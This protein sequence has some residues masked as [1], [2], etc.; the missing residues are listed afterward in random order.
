MNTAMIRITDIGL[1]I[2]AALAVMGYAGKVSMGHAFTILALMVAV[3]SIVKRLEPLSKLDQEQLK[4]AAKNIG[5]I[6]IPLGLAVGLM[7][8]EIGIL[9]DK[10]KVKWGQVNL[11]TAGVMISMM[12]MIMTLADVVTRIAKIPQEDF[13][14]ASRVIQSLLLTLTAAVALMGGNVGGKD[15]F[16]WGDVDFKTFAVMT[17]LI[18]GIIMLVNQVT[19]LAEVSKDNSSGL[20]QGT[21]IIGALAATLVGVIGLYGMIENKFG[22]F[23][24][25]DIFMVATV[26][27]G[28][29][30]LGSLANKLGEMPLGEALQG[31]GSII[32]IVAA[33][34][35]ATY[36]LGSIKSVVW[37]V[38]V[39]MVLMGG[40]VWLIGNILQQ[41]AGIEGIP[42][43][44]LVIGGIVL[45]MGIA[46]AL[47]NMVGQGGSGLT[48]VGT[49]LAMAVVVAAAGW[50]LSQVAGLPIDAMIGAT[51]AIVVII[52]LVALAA[53]LLGSNPLTMATLFGIAAVFASI[54]VAAIGMGL[55]LKLGA[56]GLTILWELLK[57]VVDDIN[58]GRLIIDPEMLADTLESVFRGIL[59]FLGRLPGWLLS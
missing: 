54:G 56:E 15:G 9:G 35:L 40:I 4:L 34:A 16:T 24:G 3:N 58:N 49:I 59:E 8:G 25:K 46:A 30:F 7:G 41:I 2:T 45:A 6:M 28:L 37:S 12:F 22:D 27:I 32:G 21:T 57:T 52:G 18:V 1:A 51:I 5:L 38:M 13:T 53:G 44:A 11:G 31:V 50:A 23:D 55:G 42:E 29:M 10:F 20:T 19:Q 14:K 43:A 47:F 26:I 39:T 17:G 33:L 36:A 48:T